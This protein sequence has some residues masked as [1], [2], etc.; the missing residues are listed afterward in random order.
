MLVD[1]SHEKKFYVS[2]RRKIDATVAS[3]LSQQQ[4]QYEQSAEFQ[5][6]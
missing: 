5:M 4:K 3:K 1:K 6:G 2:G